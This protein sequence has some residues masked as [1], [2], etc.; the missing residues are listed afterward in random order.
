MLLNPR[1]DETSQLP[2]QPMFSL[3]VPGRLPSWN[4]ILAMEHWARY[5]F[6]KELADVFLSALRASGGDC[7]TKIISAKSTIA[8]Y[9]GT[10]ESYLE[11]AL[12]RRKLRSAN[13]KLLKA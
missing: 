8:T 3:M 7:S 1:L 10:L 4:Q 6:K 2:L 11:T 13:K 5:K 9:A 12:Q